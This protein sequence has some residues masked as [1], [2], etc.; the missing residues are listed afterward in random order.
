[1]FI[2][3]LM[4]PYPYQL[5]RAL[6]NGQNCIISQF[7]N[8]PKRHIKH[9]DK[10]DSVGVQKKQLGRADCTRLT[11]TRHIYT[12]PL[13]WLCGPP[14]LGE[15]SNCTCNAKNSF[16]NPTTQLGDLGV[17]TRVPFTPSGH[18][19]GWMCGRQLRVVWHFSLGGQKSS[20]E[21]CLH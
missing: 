4:F 3:Y 8:S 10:P 12:L 11:L 1:M 21:P 17:V 15:S 5:L 7:I 16:I 19:D 18:P 20:S 2:F 6:M 13:G 14:T 9:S